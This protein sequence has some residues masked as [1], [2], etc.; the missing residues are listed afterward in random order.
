[1]FIR[2]CSRVSRWI[3]IFNAFPLICRLLGGC[4]G[5]DSSDGFISVLKVYLEHNT[6]KDW[7]FFRQAAKEIFLRTLVRPIG[8]LIL[9][10]GFRI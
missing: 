2:M 3:L 9:D 4:E 5:S 7:S 10:Q 6:K 8:A 1:M